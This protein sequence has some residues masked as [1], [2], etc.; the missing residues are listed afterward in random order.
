M[1]GELRSNLFQAASCCAETPHDCAEVRG[2]SLERY[3]CEG[4]EKNLRTESMSNLVDDRVT[5]MVAPP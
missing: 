3:S 5:V 4:S 2:L 1:T